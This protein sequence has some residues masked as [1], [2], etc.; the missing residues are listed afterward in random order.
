MGRKESVC[1]FHALISLLRIGRFS[2]RTSRYECAEQSFSESL[3]DSCNEESFSSSSSNAQR[4]S[5]FLHP[6][7]TFFRPLVCPFNRAHSR[8][9]ANN[10]N[11]PPS[12]HC[13]D[14]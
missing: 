12:H 3:P 13:G 6:G 9:S 2:G 4:Q 7:A 10:N 8:A 14:R 1:G 5:E 11:G